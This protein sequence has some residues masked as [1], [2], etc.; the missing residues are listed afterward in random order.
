M[1]VIG[2]INGIGG[3]VGSHN[4]YLRLRVKVDS[5]LAGRHRGTRSQPDPQ[6]GICADKV[7]LS[8]SD[9][10][11]LLSGCN[12]NNR[13]TDSIHQLSIIHSLSK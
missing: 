10:G 5:E 4:V 11:S 6:R 8:H 9:R 7:P 1:R 2:T 3:L 12:Y 13:L